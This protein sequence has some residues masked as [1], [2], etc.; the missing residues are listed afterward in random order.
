[1]VLLQ[2]Y[3]MFLSSKTLS[4]PVWMR[5]RYSPSSGSFFMAAT[6]ALMGKPAWSEG[7]MAE[8]DFSMWT[9]FSAVL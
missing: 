2:R 6:A 4:R 8:E 1:M 9:V 3:S 7:Y 5:S